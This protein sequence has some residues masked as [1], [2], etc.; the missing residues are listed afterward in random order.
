MTNF[1]ATF[2]AARESQGIS[3]DQIA[4]KTRISVR[5][6]SAIENEDFHVLPGGIFN[7]GFVKTFAEALGLNAEEAVAEF[8]R[9]TAEHEPSD[10]APASTT[11]TPKPS[12]NIYL[13]PIFVLAIAIAIFYVATRNSGGPVQVPI[14]PPAPAAPPPVIEQ[15][16]PP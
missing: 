13:V 11:D 3:L 15:P 1:G 5:F 12:R 7:R 4:Q 16:A 2:K 8:Q 9:I 10:V 6:L 14:T